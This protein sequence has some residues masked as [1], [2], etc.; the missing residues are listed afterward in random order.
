MSC[1]TNILVQPFITFCQGDMNTLLTGRPTSALC[2]W[3]ALSPVPAPLPTR[4]RIQTLT[5]PWA[6]DVS[7]G[8]LLH[9]LS[10]S[11]DLTDL[12]VCLVPV[13]FFLISMAEVL[14]PAMAISCARDQIRSPV[15]SGT[16]FL[17]LFSVSFVSLS[18]LLNIKKHTQGAFSG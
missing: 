14:P 13:A 15:F 16:L 17:H 5:T 9:V 2:V 1:T 18:S 3:S 10:L 4:P 7:A 11:L 8:N 12:S 6:T